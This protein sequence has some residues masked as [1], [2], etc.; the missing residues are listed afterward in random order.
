MEQIVARVW[1]AVEG[2]KPVQAAED[3][4]VNRFGG[5]VLLL[6]VP[7]EEL[8]ER[9]SGDELARE[10]A[11]GAQLAQ[12]VGNTDVGMS[13]VVAGEHLLALGLSRVIDL[14]L[15]PL[16]Q[17]VDEGTGVQSGKCGADDPA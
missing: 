6:L 9:R 8:V 17:L 10:H 7:L 3:K 2:V 12:H 13:V 15:Q 1:I 14:L 16:A 5:Q 4:P 11:G